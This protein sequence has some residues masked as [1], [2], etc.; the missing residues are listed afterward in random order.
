MQVSNY[1]GIKNKLMHIFQCS[2]REEGR[3]MEETDKGRKGGIERG[4][5]EEEE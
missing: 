5:K 1:E 4:D 3:E 2:N